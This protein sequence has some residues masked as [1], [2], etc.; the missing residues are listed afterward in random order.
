M[1]N[2]NIS[3]SIINFFNNITNADVSISMK[4]R[5]ADETIYFN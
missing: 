5:V 4:W 2:K 1:Y 3:N